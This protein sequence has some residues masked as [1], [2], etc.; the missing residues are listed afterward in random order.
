MKNVYIITLAMLLMPCISFAQ[1]NNPK[2]IFDKTIKTSAKKAE[3]LDIS[4]DN[5]YIIYTEET[6]SDIN[7]NANL[8]EG[9]MSH[10]TFMLYDCITNKKT[11]IATSDDPFEIEG[12]GKAL[13]VYVSNAQYLKGKVIFV[14]PAWVTCDAVM[15]YD[16]AT[17]NIKLLSPGFNYMVTSSGRI[18]IESTTVLENRGRVGYDIYYDVD[19]NII[20]K[21]D[22]YDF[23]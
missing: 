23:K 3:M 6:K 5:R 22:Y 10:N 17:Q 7:N 8:L 19:G 13:D 11:I 16:I 2:D 15:I 1:S 12:F 4:P 18:K 21:S 20:R 14:T 9:D